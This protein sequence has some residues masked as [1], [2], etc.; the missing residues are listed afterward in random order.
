MTERSFGV[1]WWGALVSDVQNRFKL[2][3]E[4]IDRINGTLAQH[5]ELMQ[6]RLRVGV[7]RGTPEGM[8][9]IW[10]EITEAQADDLRDMRTYAEAFKLSLEKEFFLSTVGRTPS[11]ESLVREYVRKYTQ[12]SAHINPFTGETIRIDSDC[13]LQAIKMLDTIRWRFNREFD[14]ELKSYARVVLQ[15]LEIL[16]SKEDA[17]AVADS[18]GMSHD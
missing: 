14:Y 12:Y 1:R 7:P 8:L 17:I 3:Q 16:R 4:Q 2:I 11:Q 9:P 18:W 5:E 13:L 6:E 10:P 15:R